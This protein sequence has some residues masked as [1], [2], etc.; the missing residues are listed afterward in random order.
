MDTDDKATAGAIAGAALAGVPLAVPVSG[1]P[2][3]FVV[4]FTGWAADAQFETMI[5]KTNTAT[6]IVNLPTGQRVNVL[7][8]PAGTL[9]AGRIAKLQVSFG[10]GQVHF[11]GDR[12]PP[13]ADA[14]QLDVWATLQ[15]TIT[16]PYGDVVQGSDGKPVFTPRNLTILGR[17]SS[18][19]TDPSSGRAG[20]SPP[21]AAPAQFLADCLNDQFGP[22]IK[23]IPYNWSH[24]GHVASDGESQANE[25][26]NASQFPAD[27]ML[28]CFGMNDSQ[29]SAYNAGQQ[30]IYLAG[31]PYYEAELRKR[32]QFGIGLVVLCT[33]PHQHTGRF[34]N[35]FGGNNMQWPYYKAAPVAAEEIVPPVSKALIT[36][37]WTGS[38]IKRQ[39][40]VRAGHV[41]LCIRN[42]ARRMN[43]DPKTRDR[44][45]LLDVEWAW[46]RYGVEQ[47]SLDQLFNTGEIVHPNLLG[48]QVSYQQ[49]IREFAAACRR[50]RGSQWSFRGEGVV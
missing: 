25:A 20:A 4:N 49:C 43:L 24:G 41:N 22:G 39:G 18:V 26:Y 27:I 45:I 2:N 47:Y 23:T 44:I 38:G 48:H 46:F 32:L 13:S 11:M 30:I 14:Q 33:T 40:D 28:D 5:I 1:D 31:T 37:D 35:T 9:K 6:A 3:E 34:T 7:E 12:A 42:I 15:R 16:N 10:D 21:G 50:G 17:G 29:A 36:R 19:A 8:A